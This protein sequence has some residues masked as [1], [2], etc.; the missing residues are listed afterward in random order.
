MITDEM[1][2]LIRNH[3]LAFVASVDEDGTPNLSPKAT[4]LV[5]DDKHIGFGH[6]RSP[7]T[8]RNIEQRPVVELN[9]ID[10]FARKGFRFKGPATYEKRGTERFASLLPS[11]AEWGELRE[12]FLGI[13]VVRIERALAVTSPAYDSGA[14]EKDLTAQWRERYFNL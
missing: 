5:L 4:M 1:R 3:S 12:S 2:E 6:L 7:N 8:I 14:T 9:F 13:V 11:F 10:V